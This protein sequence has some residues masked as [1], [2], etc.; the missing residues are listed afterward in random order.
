MPCVKT[1]TYGGVLYPD[2][3]TYDYE[4]VLLNVKNYFVEFAYILHDK[5]VTEDGEVKKAH[6]H[7][8][9]RRKNASSLEYV[10]EV[11][12][13][14][15]NEIEAIRNWKG[16]VRYLTH[17]DYPDKYRYE[18][19]DIVT[20][21]DNIVAYF[22]QISE[23][24]AVLNMIE[25]REKGSTYKEILIKAVEGGYYDSFRRNIGIV[26]MVVRDQQNADY[27]RAYENG[28]EKC[29]RKLFENVD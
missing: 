12:G 15:E 7:W 21:M 10:A 18:V 1:R 14:K 4:E 17:V 27:R 29:E 24:R 28:F 23:G 19:D 16:A 11:M 9:G 26:D 2:S 25:L 13:L 6:M 22:E 8:L 3:E 5:D 20:N